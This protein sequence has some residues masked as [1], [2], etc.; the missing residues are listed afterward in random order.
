M[1]CV[2]RI[3]LCNLVFGLSRHRLWKEFEP[4]NEQNPIGCPS[5]FERTQRPARRV[6]NQC[7]DMSSFLQTHLACMRRAV[8]GRA[9][10][11]LAVSSLLFA[12]GCGELLCPE[13]LSVVEGSCQKLDAE[14]EGQPELLDDPAPNDEQTPDVELCDGIDNDGDEAIDENWPSLGEPCGDRAGVGVCVAGVYACAPDGRGVVCDAAVLPSDEVCDGADNDC[15]GLVDEGVLSVKAEAFSDH[16]T[17]TSVEGGFVVTRIIS[18]QV[19]VETYDTLGNRTGHHDDIDEP[20]GDISFMES[21]ASGRRVLVTLGKLSFHVLDVDVDS[22]LVPIIVEAREL[23]AA[24]RQ[25][26]DLGVY[27]PPYHP[28][29]VS[30]PSRFIGYQ[31]LVT[32]ALTPLGDVGLSGLG[33]EPIPV[34]I[35]PYTPFDAAGPFVLWE[36]A[37]NLRAGWLLDDGMLVLDIDVGRGHAP[38]ISIGEGGPGVAYLEDGRLRLSELGGLSLQC[39]EGRFCHAQIEADELAATQSG[40][41]AL[42]YDDA[43]DTWFVAAGRELAVVGR[44]DQMP[45]IKQ[46]EV[47]DTLG[48]APNR[49][50]V[51]VSGSTAAVL[52]TSASGGSALTFLGCF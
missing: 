27:D 32:F 40:P 6:D 39:V 18:D 49:L 10:W 2:D 29:V 46:A 9:S 24:W 38:A 15:D 37:D 1:S 16:A 52:Q 11:L 34:L 35:R 4:R 12:V 31:D 45:V 36:Q 26:I 8:S 48:V 3:S 47:L 7:N 14:A 21:D 44:S 17:V 50:D 23:H 19:R 51:A 33:A 20:S 5:A 43:A 42:A 30:S 25:G 13:P 22:R 41:T 28:R